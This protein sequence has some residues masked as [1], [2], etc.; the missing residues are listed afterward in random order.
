MA[1]L[2]HRTTGPTIKRLKEHA[3]KIKDREFSRLINKLENKQSLDPNAKEA[4]R[5]AFDRLVNKILHPPLE[6][7]RDE[8]ESGSPHRLLEAMKQLF[9]LKD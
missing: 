2:C 3:G 6:S 9:Q 8:A 7:L 4:I 1:E 5:L